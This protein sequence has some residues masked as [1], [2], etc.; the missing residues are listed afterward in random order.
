MKRRILYHNKGSC[1]LPPKHSFLIIHEFHTLFEIPVR[2]EDITDILIMLATKILTEELLSDGYAT[3]ETNLQS[4]LL[5]IFHNLQL[6]M[7]CNKKVSLFSF[8]GF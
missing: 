5:L 6:Y 8:P 3:I 2:K 7:N 4:T 1:E